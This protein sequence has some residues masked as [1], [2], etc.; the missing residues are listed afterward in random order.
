MNPARRI[1]RATLLLL[2][3][4]ALLAGFAFALPR[5]KPVPETAD[6]ELAALRNE[7]DTLA[8]NDDAT[9]A[10]LRRQ[11]REQT[12]PTWTNENVAAR[13]GSGW[14][15][16]WQPSEGTGRRV[17]LTREN[18]RFAEWPDY[19]RAVKA[20]S[21]T[22]GVVLESLDVAAQGT[23]TGRRFTEVTLGLRI[24]SGPHENSNRPDPSG[25]LTGAPTEITTQ[26]KP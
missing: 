3:T 20:W 1:S 6:T 18:P 22:P 8:G 25:S 4:S 5:L 15:L 19:L 16:D 21:A 24:A 2:V 14:R 10:R 17:R 13:A 12:A 26:P 11:G 23:G 9:L 7:R